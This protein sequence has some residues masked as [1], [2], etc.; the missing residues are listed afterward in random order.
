MSVEVPVEE[1]TVGRRCVLLNGHT[2][3]VQ[4]VDT[5]GGRT[6]VRWKAGPKLGTQHR[7]AGEPELLGTFLPRAPGETI[8]VQEML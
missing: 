4:S 1:F 5:A 2:V 7:L 6:W 8:A 3:R